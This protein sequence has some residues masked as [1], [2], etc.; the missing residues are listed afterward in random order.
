[1]RIRWPADTDRKEKESYSWHMFQDEDWYGK[2]HKDAHL[3]WRFTADELDKRA[4]RADAAGEA[5][6]AHK[7]RK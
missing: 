4:E 2:T 5:G 7:R 3:S 6:P 1:M